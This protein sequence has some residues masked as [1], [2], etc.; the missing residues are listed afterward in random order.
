VVDRVLA[1]VVAELAEHG[2]EAFS[3]ERVARAAEVN[4]TS[5]YR[6]WPTREEL[7][8]AALART[9]AQVTEAIEATESL[10]GDLRA[11]VRAV[12]AVFAGPDGAALLRAAMQ[13]ELGS[14]AATVAARKRLE[15]QV[16]AP[17]GAMVRRARERGEWREGA[18]GELVAFTLVGAVMHRV[19]LEQAPLSPRWQRS[20]VEQVLLGALSRS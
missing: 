1:C 10:K 20:L 8:A 13:S 17:I 11:I 12:C 7:I 3:V 4:K 18:S 9:S 5:V 16:A 2:A 6:R 15:R 14:S 19:L